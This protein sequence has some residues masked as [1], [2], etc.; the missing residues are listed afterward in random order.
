MRFFSLL[1]IALF[2]IPSQAQVVNVSN[3]TQLQNAL[4]A[5]VPG[6]TIVLADGIYSKSGS[7]V[8]PERNGTAVSPIILKGSLNAIITCSNLSSG[9]GL[10]VRGSNYWIF[11]GFSIYNCSKGIVLDSSNYG[12]VKNITVRKI[13]YEGIHL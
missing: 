11:D 10:S 2:V 4:N 12:I 1:F 8:I 3:A 9:Y 6:Q 5:A 13:G 7:F